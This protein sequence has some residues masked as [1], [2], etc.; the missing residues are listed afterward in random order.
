MVTWI[1][2]YLFKIKNFALQNYCCISYIL[3][4]K[5]NFLFLQKHVLWI[6]SEPLVENGCLTKSSF[7]VGP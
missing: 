1:F 2:V 3:S 6:K 4:G 7:L 5:R